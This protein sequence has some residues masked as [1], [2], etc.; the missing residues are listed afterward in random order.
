M[1]LDLNTMHSQDPPIFASISSTTIEVLPFLVNQPWNDLAAAYVHALRPSYIRFS[2]GEVFCDS[3]IWRV[4]VNLNPD[5]RI[6]G[7]TQEVHV[8]LPHGVPHGAALDYALDQQIH[9]TK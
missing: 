4:T 1:T 9:Q 7:I 5:G 2:K 6:T 3:R 8:G